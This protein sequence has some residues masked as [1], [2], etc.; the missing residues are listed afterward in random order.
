VTD[1]KPSARQVYCAAHMM[2]ELL[3]LA[4]PADRRQASELI[5]KLREAQAAHQ[6]AQPAAGDFEAGF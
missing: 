4:W 3:G 6:A 2:A 1:T 5:G